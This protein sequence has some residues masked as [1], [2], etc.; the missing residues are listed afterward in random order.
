[1][2][3]FCKK[4]KEIL[5]PIAIIFLVF[6][7][8]CINPVRNAFIGALGYLAYFYL[9]V[10]VFCIGLYFLPIRIVISTKRKIFDIITL[11]LI[12]F[13]I[14]IFVIG[15]NN[16]SFS[17]Y[18]ADIYF[19]KSFGGVIFS[20]VSSPIVLL[21]GYTI[22]LILFFVSSAVCLFFV[23]FPYIALVQNKE[24]DHLKIEKK[25]KQVKKATQNTQEFTKIK[26]S[27]LY[28]ERIATPTFVKDVTPKNEEVVIEKKVEEVKLSAKE[29]LFGD[30]YKGISAKDNSVPTRTRP[31]IFEEKEIPRLILNQEKPRLVLNQEKPIVTEERKLDTKA[32]LFGRNN[33]N[34]YHEED[35]KKN[36]LKDEIKRMEN[37]VYIPKTVLYESRKAEFADI[38]EQKAKATQDILSN[39]GSEPKEEV[40]AQEQTPPTETVI[41]EQEP[42][43]KEEVIENSTQ[44]NND[45]ACEQNFEEETTELSTVVENSIAVEKEESSPIVERSIQEV[46][47][48][49][50]FIPKASKKAL[51]GANLVRPN[52]Q[53][54]NE[55]NYNAP[56][57]DVFINHV[58]KDFK[59]EI[60]NY[61]LAK[62]VFEVV[63]KGH[64]VDCKLNRAIKGPT[65]TTFFLLL[66]PS[67][68]SS[69]ILSRRND[70]SRLLKA[71]GKI[72]IDTT[73]SGT[74]EVAIMV[75][76][77]IPGVV[78][79][80][81][82]L[83][84]EE[85]KS[86][87][88]ELN[89]AVGISANGDVLIDD[90]IDLPHL[91]VAGST[92]MGK[93]VFLNSLL[94]SLLYK[95]SPSELQLILVDL[96][97]VEMCSYNNLPHLL[98]GQSLFE[99]PEVQNAL[100]WVK[101]EAERRFSFLANLPGN[102][103]SIQEYNASVPKN[104]RLPYIIV[105]IDEASELM[106]DLSAKK[107]LET[108]LISLAR[109]G[110]AAG[111]HLI[112]ATQNPNKKTITNEIQTNLNTKISFAV[113][114]SVHSRIIFDAVGA[115]KLVGKGDMLIKK[116]KE[117]VRAQAPLVSGEEIAEMVNYIVKNNKSTLDEQFVEKVLSGDFERNLLDG[118][119]KLSLAESEDFEEKTEQKS[120]K[121]NNL[122]EKV[123]QETLKWL[124]KEN[125]VSISFVQRRMNKGFNAASDILE[126]LAKRGHVVE[127]DR[128]KYK[129]NISKEDFMEIYPDDDGDFD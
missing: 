86:A 123:L 101:L 25:V 93:S 116:S 61:G 53:Y 35:K 36:I 11:F 23:F 1:M 127:Y 72:E 129:L 44:E 84:S 124:I 120:K 83:E 5:V 16:I 125:K 62:H 9:F 94:S 98:F 95:Y 46:Q 47:K 80:R 67:C 2:Q 63:L 12:F 103:R 20:L 14:H 111:V 122:S 37:S 78:S 27:E 22:S 69:K 4:Y 57:I 56:P 102:V 30:Y 104:E 42:V 117:M 87:K 40:V 89:F 79:L 110:R 73:V 128:S 7:L 105:V 8:F 18:V 112:F 99:I 77:D 115:E 96:K 108:A 76:N 118:G 19:T 126:E 52:P 59:L 6:I 74:D 121:D 109:K 51:V 91:L 81:K 113:G 41:F 21:L 43:A 71:K 66:D 28:I 17:G 58:Q 70:I 29:R 106:G 24:L 31:P 15:G 50:T 54:Y 82:M 10:G 34:T 60:E 64:G 107:Y 26:D 49:V 45:I 85:Y 88:G 75:P 55:Y 3:N 13:T 119:E 68:P 39:Y 92:K 32:I 65:I 100:K 38:E 48:E 114:E 33:N 90:F 97:L